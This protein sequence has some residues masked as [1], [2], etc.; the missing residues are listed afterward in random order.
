MSAFTVTANGL[1]IYNAMFT[2]MSKGQGCICLLIM[3]HH[4]MSKQL[5]KAIQQKCKYVLMASFFVL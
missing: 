1:L 5:K 3:F 2:L 4:K